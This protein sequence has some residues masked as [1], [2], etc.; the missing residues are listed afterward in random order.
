MFSC[1]LALIAGMLYLS[2]Q[3]IIHRDLKSLNVLLSSVPP[4]QKQIAKICDFGLSREL[5]HITLV[6][7][8]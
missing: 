5:D 8:E 6:C 4:P 2:S 3:H 7:I 1:R